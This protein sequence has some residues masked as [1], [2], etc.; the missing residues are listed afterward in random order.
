MKRRLFTLIELLVV[1]AIIA[2]LAA[3]LLPA[4]SKAREKARSISCINNH[5][6]LVTAGIMYGDDNEGWWVHNGGSLRHSD[7]AYTTAHYNL[8]PYLGGM[9]LEDLK[10]KSWQATSDSLIPP[11]FYCPSQ[12]FHKDCTAEFK[13]Y[14]TYAFT[15]GGN[16]WF[17]ISTWRL[18]MTSSSTYHA[19]RKVGHSEM[20]FSGDKMATNF[21]LGNNRFEISS[22]NYGLPNFCHNGRANVSLFDGSARGIEPGDI[23]GYANAKYVMGYNGRYESMPF[24]AYYFNRVKIAF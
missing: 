17:K 16:P 12:I 19:T 24:G 4:L 13:G 23:K 10:G 11:M 8:I 20:L 5:K 15:G 1:I 21:R 7:P 2:I 18:W 3:M 6:Q 14:D 22:D 9:S